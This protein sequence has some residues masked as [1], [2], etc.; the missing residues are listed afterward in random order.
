MNSAIT[1]GTP[2]DIEVS[3]L[4]ASAEPVGMRSWR[5]ARSVHVRTARYLGAAAASVWGY[6]FVRVVLAVRS[7]R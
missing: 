2:S 6:D 1:V 4:L 5:L 7:T 3:L